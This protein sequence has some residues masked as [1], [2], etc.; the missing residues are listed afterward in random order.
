LQKGNCHH[1]LSEVGEW[2]R[3]SRYVSEGAWAAIEV[4]KEEWAKKSWSKL[5]QGG[6]LEIQGTRLG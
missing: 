5:P 3:F 1:Q 6:G 4:L 2:S